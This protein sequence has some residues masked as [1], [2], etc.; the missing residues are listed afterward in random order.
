MKSKMRRALGFAPEA[1]ESPDTQA[2]LTC[3]DKE[4]ESQE[5][6]SRRLE[7]CGSPRGLHA[8]PWGS[9]ELGQLLTLKNCLWKKEAT[10]FAQH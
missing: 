2:L 3:A 5:A 4:E 10:G 8:G 9:L 6:R 7:N 1:R